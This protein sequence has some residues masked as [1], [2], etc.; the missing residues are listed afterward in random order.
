M[1]DI[2]VLV[3]GNGSSTK[4]YKFGNKIDDYDIFKFTLKDATLPYICLHVMKYLYGQGY[5]NINI[6]TEEISDIK[7]YNLEATK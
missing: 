4:D 3:I 2:K 6:M 5:Y 1:S 7:E